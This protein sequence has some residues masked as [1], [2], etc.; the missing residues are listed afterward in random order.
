MLL[1]Y[2]K[3]TWAVMRRRRFFT[4]I[5]LFGISFTLL[6]LILLTAFIEHLLGPNYPEWNR[7][8]MAYVF[9]V[10]QKN[11]EKGWSRMGPASYS[12][13]RQFI[14]PLQTAQKVAVSA[15]PKTINAYA[16]NQKFRLYYR[17]TDAVFWEV[18]QFDFLEGRPYTEQDMAQNAF[19]V[20]IDDSVRERY[21]GKNASAVGK[22]IEIENVVYHVAGVVKGVPL[23]RFQTC[24]NVWMPLNTLKYDL[25][26]P[27][28]NGEFSA[29][30]LPKSDK[31]VADVEKEYAEVVARIPTQDPEMDK[32]SSHAGSYV[33]L[34]SRML[35]GDGEVERT[36]T[37]FL[38]LS[39]F[40]LLFMLIPALNLINLNISRILERASE[41]GV[42]RACGASARHLIVQF[43]IE[44]LLIAIFGGLLAVVLAALIV[45]LFN[46]SDL[47]AFADLH[48]NWTVAAIAFALSLVFGLLSGVYPAWRMSKLAP[49]EALKSEG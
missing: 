11:S 49:A 35:L 38:L 12:Y 5:S 36:G 27:Q 1:N 30:I 43:T 14:K 42:R 3:I 45:M 32:I 21:F 18:T 2:I 23:I 8:E 46:R 7:N 15:T 44:N 47:Y 17:H 13:I 6:I 34:F 22:T 48:V 20:V 9:M 37:F 10:Q 24:A 40:A 4:F 28:Y 26:D 25:N 41:I 31:T 33:S 29:L 19:V 16:G 39:V